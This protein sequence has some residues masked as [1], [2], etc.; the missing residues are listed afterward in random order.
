[1][2]VGKLESGNS[3]TAVGP[4]TK[5][6]DHA[7]GKYQVMGRNIG[8]WTLA[9]LGVRMTIEQFVA[10]PLAQEK[11][12]GIIFTQRI[13]QR[14]NTHDAIAMWFSGQPLE[15]NIAKDVTGTTVPQYVAKIL[16]INEAQAHY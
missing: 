8:T 2:G 10:S 6:G 15:G 12:A 7:Y 14:G 9:H 1:M 5:N 3:Y 4:K 13:G 11:L 16:H